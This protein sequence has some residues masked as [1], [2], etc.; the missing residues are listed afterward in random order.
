MNPH[1]DDWLEQQRQRN[2]RSHRRLLRFLDDT[3][4]V[5]VP[6]YINRPKTDLTSSRREFRFHHGVPLSDMRTV[7][8]WLLTHHPRPRRLATLIPKLWKRHGR[9]DLTM[10]GLLMANL[11]PSI[12]SQDPWMA[13]IHL[14]KRTE[15]LL[16]VLEVAEELVRGGH[17]VPDDA[18]ML[19]AG[20]Q[21]P[22]GT[23][24]RCCSSRFANHHRN[25]CVPTSPRLQRAESCTSASVN[26][27]LNRRIDGMM[28][29][30]HGH[31]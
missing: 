26:V 11:D 7:A 9:E 4:R 13:F 24:T 25:T 6:D 28:T 31:G 16:A 15:P 19:A 14:L 18:W 23:N 8:S 30:T 17:P 3:Y 10:A 27:S 2:L 5:C 22:R 20:Q 29:P 12:L 21:S 1:L